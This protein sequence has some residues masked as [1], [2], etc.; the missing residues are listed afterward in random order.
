[1]LMLLIGCAHW[2]AY[3]RAVDLEARGDFQGAS[4]AAID[5]LE[6]QPNYPEA[7]QILERTWPVYYLSA[8]GQINS[9]LAQ[10]DWD[11]AVSQF[12][13]LM[14]LARRIAPLGF[15]VPLGDLESRYHDTLDQAAA[16]YYEKGDQMDM[17]GQKRDAARAFRRAEAL[18]PGYRDAAARYELARLAG[19]VRVA[20]LPFSNPLSGH[21]HEQLYAKLLDRCLNSKLE[22]VHFTDNTGE[23]RI[24]GEMV[25][26]YA[27]IPRDEITFTEVEAPTSDPQATQARLRASFHHRQITNRVVVSATVRMYQG[28]K[29]VLS[30]NLTETVNDS[31]EW[32]ENIQGDRRAL[33]QW[34]NLEN[35]SHFP[36]SHAELNDEASD[37]LA[38]RLFEEIA[39]YLTKSL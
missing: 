4:A 29:L 20:V 9:A 35:R 31:T 33:G 37:R 22:F 14:P 28:D 8:T 7:R 39:N 5:A 25:Q 1:M 26:A 36:K 34:A 17:Q 11:R 16:Y 18:I 27:G 10:G 15:G 13:Q 2:F 12:Q 6:Q 38:D 19:L 30:K 32:I 21:L 3:H 24:Q 23:F